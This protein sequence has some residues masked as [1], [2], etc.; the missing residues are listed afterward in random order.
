MQT[1]QERARMV[2]A[3]IAFLANNPLA[4]NEYERYLLGRFV[5]GE[6]TIYQVLEALAAHQEHWPT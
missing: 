1:Q 4:T 5:A 6:L 3:T 2:E